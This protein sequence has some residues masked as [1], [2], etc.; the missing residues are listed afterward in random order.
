MQVCD[1]EDFKNIFTTETQ[2]IS[3]SVHEKSKQLVFKL[4]VHLATCQ[5][6]VPILQYGVNL[7][8]SALYLTIMH[9]LTFIFI[10]FSHSYILYVMKVLNGV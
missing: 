2:Q 9:F 1:Y 10:P 5:N 8:Q 7:R 6:T 4:V 3:S